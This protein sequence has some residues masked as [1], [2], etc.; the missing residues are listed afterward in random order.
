M[1]ASGTSPQPSPKEREPCT[2]RGPLLRE[3]GVRGGSEKG[4]II[5]EKSKK[6]VGTR[7]AAFL[8]GKN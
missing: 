6:N 8:E 2:Q 3:G 7:R 1:I 5:R 4:A